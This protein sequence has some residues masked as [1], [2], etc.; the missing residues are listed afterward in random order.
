MELHKLLDQKEAKVCVW[1]G[2]WV[3]VWVG[4]GGYV[5]SGLG[6]FVYT[7]VCMSTV[8]ACKLDMF[9]KPYIR[10]VLLWW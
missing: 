9:N 5:V 3:G 6:V 7:C 10:S 8:F 1:V 4:M 2:G